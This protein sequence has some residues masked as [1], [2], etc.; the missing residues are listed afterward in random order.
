MSD[1]TGDS[2]SEAGDARSASCGRSKDDHVADS[3]PDVRDAEHEGLVLGDEDE[4]DVE[5][6]E[7]ILTQDTVWSGKI[8]NVETSDVRLPNGRCSQRDVVRHVGAVAIVAL[9]ETG[10]IALVRQYRTALDRVTVEIPAGKIDPGEEPLEA[11]RRELKE[12]TGF[13][14]GRIAYLTTIATSPGFTDELIH[15]YFATQLELGDACP[16]EDEFL[17]VDLVDVHE[18]VDAV[19]DGK[20]EDAKTV[21]GALACDVMAH[22]LEQ[23]L[24]QPHED[25]SAACDE[26][27]I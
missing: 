13:V 27:D 20:I 24:S 25:T 3:E 1:T 18:L 26:R 7:D 12:E 21:I 8:F 6:H 15:L 23:E 2:G 10:K 16:D 17:N 22:R 14:P 19:L 9:T 4:H 5:L 11:A